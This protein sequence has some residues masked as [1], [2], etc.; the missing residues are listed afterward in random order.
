MED[1]IRD[2]LRGLYIEEMRHAHAYRQL[3]IFETDLE[4]KR[5]LNRLSRI[6]SHHA[7]LWGKLVDTKTVDG[8]G[9]AVSIDSASLKL[10]RRTL[11]L[12]MTVKLI[13]YRELSIYKRL[14]RMKYLVA[15]EDERKT[16]RRIEA[17][18]IKREYPLIDRIMEYNPIVSNIRDITFGLN[19]GLVEVLAATVGLG[20]ALQNPVLVLIGGMIVAVSGTASMAGGAYLATE[21]ER[22]TKKINLVKKSA[23]KS[24]F[25]VGIP[26]IIGAIFPLFPFLLGYGGFSG[27]V[28]SLA[29]TTAVLAVDSV[30]IAILTDVGIGRRVLSTL[31]ISIGAALFAI[32]L[33][34]VARIKFHVSV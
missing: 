4:T 28:F 19:D 23:I 3:A 8:E 7:A 25:Y 13:A 9:Y 15:G 29:L 5:I 18:E 10:V 16:I 21:Y 6:E 33:G 30:I 32:I 27:I 34:Y 11:G 17:D 22:G 12:L 31:A 2:S 14:D 1:K 20:A 24:A 26:Y